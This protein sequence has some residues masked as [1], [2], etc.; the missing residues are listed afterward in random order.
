M[1]CQQ[2]L[3][4]SVVQLKSKH[5]RKPHC[6]NGVVDMF[7]PG[8]SLYLDNRYL[9]PSLSSCRSEGPECPQRLLCQA[10][11]DIFSRGHVIPSVMTYLSNLVMSIMVENT[12]TSEM[13]LAAQHGRKGQVDCLKTY[14]KCQMKLW[15][16]FSTDIQDC[17]KKKVRDQC[18]AKYPNSPKIQMN[19]FSI[20]ET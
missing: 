16:I 7:G 11:Q 1:G 12:K 9:I 10:N 13:L 17:I 3:P 18:F 20:N 14:S 6:H 8:H 19:K 2:C 4:L 5:C 15:K